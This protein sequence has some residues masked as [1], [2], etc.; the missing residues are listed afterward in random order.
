M[1]FQFTVGDSGGPTAGTS[2]FE[3]T[4]LKW[5]F[6]NDIT[7]NNGVQNQLEPNPEFTHNYV[8]GRLKLGNNNEWKLGDKLI[9]D[10]DKCKC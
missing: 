1:T 10:Y 6:I 8:Q 5:I 2:T 9:I 3:S 4:L 7:I